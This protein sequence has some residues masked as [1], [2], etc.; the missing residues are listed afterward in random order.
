MLN[1]MPRC[2]LTFRTRVTSNVLV[3]VTN[4]MGD[5]IHRS[6]ASARVVSL[7]LI[8]CFMEELFRSNLLQI[9]VILLNRASIKGK[10]LVRI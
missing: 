2:L 8:S 7:G 3:N 9:Y 5:F 6:N 1:F 4:G 10:H